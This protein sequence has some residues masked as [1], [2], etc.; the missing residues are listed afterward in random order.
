MDFITIIKEYIMI[1]KKTSTSLTLA[2]VIAFSSFLSPF[3][4]QAAESMSNSAVVLVESM[5]N[6][7]AMCT[8]I[9]A[10]FLSF[11]HLK[12]KK[13]SEDM[14]WKDCGDQ[15]MKLCKGDLSSLKRLWSAYI[16]GN[17]KK[18]VEIETTTKNGDTEEMI[19]DKKLLRK[20]F[21][22]LGMLDDFLGTM[23]DLVERVTPVKPLVGVGAITTAFLLNNTK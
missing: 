18:V 23:K 19:K 20:A 6:N 11:Y 10:L 12:N 13:A 14:G 4:L 2:M 8:L 16:V 21:G 5:K 17:S 22:L 9:S 1:K 15:F 3:R 7:K